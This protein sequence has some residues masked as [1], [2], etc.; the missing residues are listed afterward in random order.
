MPHMEINDKEIR[1]VVKK[2]LLS[3]VNT[4]SEGPI[5]E[6]FDYV[7]TLEAALG[8]YADGVFWDHGAR[9]RLALNK[10]K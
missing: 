8:Y 1:D 5:K 3:R 7:D 9:A 4:A 6:I 2:Y 10:G